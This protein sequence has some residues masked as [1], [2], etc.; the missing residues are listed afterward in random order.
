MVCSAQ[1]Q[2]KNMIQKVYNLIK[3]FNSL[4]TL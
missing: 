2:G 4:Y 3:E 1:N